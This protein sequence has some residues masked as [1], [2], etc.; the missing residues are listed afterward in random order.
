[1]L[2]FRGQSQRSNNEVVKFGFP[3]VLGP[4]KGPR[5]ESGAGWMGTKENRG[6]KIVWHAKGT[7]RLGRQCPGTGWK[8]ELR[9]QAASSS[10]VRRK[11][12]ARPHR[13]R[14]SK[15]IHKNFIARL[16]S[17]W[18]LWA[19]RDTTSRH[20]QYKM[21]IVDKIVDRMVF[22]LSYHCLYSRLD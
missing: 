11:L 2:Y 12:A 21:K 8:V 17:N 20:K 15:L 5:S 22:K 1:M 10:V 9:R 7:H 19:C 4:Q 14:V 3:S 16:R 6:M 18:F 13:T